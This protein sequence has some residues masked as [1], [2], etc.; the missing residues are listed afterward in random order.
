MKLSELKQS[1]RGHVLAIQNDVGEYKVSQMDEIALMVAQGKLSSETLTEFVH[2]SAKG[3]T[4]VT[5]ASQMFQVG[6]DYLQPEDPPEPQRM[7]RDDQIALGIPGEPD[8][9]TPFER[10]SSPT[11]QAPPPY[12]LRVLDVGRR[13]ENIILVYVP[14]QGWAS[15]YQ[16]GKHVTDKMVSEYQYDV[17]TDEKKKALTR[18]VK[19]ALTR[20]KRWKKLQNNQTRGKFYSLIDFPEPPPTA[21]QDETET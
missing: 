13:I 5:K 14:T 8:P 16:I 12:G 11:A 21:K 2:Q 9:D 4:D 1:I 10:V 20:L 6:L 15:S 17:S 7:S 18:L 19:N 3:F